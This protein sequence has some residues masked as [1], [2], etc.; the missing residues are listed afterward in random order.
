[1][2][3]RRSFGSCIMATVALGAPGLALSDGRISVGLVCKTTTSGENKPTF[4]HI[5]LDLNGQN[6]N[7]WS[8]GENGSTSV[9]FT[10]HKGG[11]VVLPDGTYLRDANKTN[12]AILTGFNPM[13]ATDQSKVSDAHAL[14]S[15][16]D[17]EFTVNV[18]S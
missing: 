6:P 9:V 12:V 5:T 2:F 17:F 11:F 8:E 1:M 7:T 14:E 16:L 15:G 10:T 4:F 18:F 13:S 3:N